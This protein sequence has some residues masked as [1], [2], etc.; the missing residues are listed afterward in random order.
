[1]KKGESIQDDFLKKKEKVHKNDQSKAIRKQIYH[2][3]SQLSNEDCYKLNEA[4]HMLEL[5]KHQYLPEE[6][7]IHMIQL[8]LD[9]FTPKGRF[10]AIVCVYQYGV[11]QGKRKLR[12]K[13][14]KMK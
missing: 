14:K 3:V 4:I 11:I 5:M 13:R 1:M 12:K 8:I 6:K 10:Y 7:E 9:L 2:E